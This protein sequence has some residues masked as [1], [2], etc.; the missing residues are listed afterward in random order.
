MIG[1]GGLSAN[2]VI[3]HTESVFARYQL[4]LTM[5]Q[6]FPQNPM[7]AN[8]ALS[9]TLSAPTNVMQEAERG[10]QTIK[11]LLKKEGDPYL[12]LLAYHRIE[13]SP[14]EL[15]EQEIMYYSTHDRRSEKAQNSR[16]LHS[17]GKWLKEDRR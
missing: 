1:L 6:N 5:D 13:Y 7:L 3:N 17:R 15:F 9:T 11:T 16:L 2:S 12:A 8:M 10:V 4:F 14:S